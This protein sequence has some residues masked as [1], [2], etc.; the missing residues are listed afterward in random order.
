VTAFEKMAAR[1][2]AP[3]PLLAEIGRVLEQ[4][5]DFRLER[6]E[7]RQGAANE[8]EMINPAGAGQASAAVA[9]DTQSER[10]EL[11][12]LHGSIGTPGMA[13]DPRRDLESAERIAAA[14]RAIRGAQ[15]TIARQPVDITSTSALTGGERKGVQAVAQ[16]ASV[17]IRITRKAGT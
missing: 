6:L 9:G 10:L 13:A 12:I 4:I 15:V 1:T 17:S 11:A 7:W 3:T 16:A 8:P 5:T 14:L 2:V